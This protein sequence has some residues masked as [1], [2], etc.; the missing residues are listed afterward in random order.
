VKSVLWQKL[1]KTMAS[2]MAALLLTTS[3][4]PSAADATSSGGNVAEPSVSGSVYG[5]QSVSS[6]A[7]ATYRLAAPLSWNLLSK[8]N[9][10]FLSMVYA[11]S[12]SP[13][14]KLSSDERYFAFM[15][16]AMDDEQ[17]TG[18]KVIEVED[19][20]T[21]QYRR[22]KTPDL[23]G[24]VLHFDMSPNG[25]YFA[26]TY[27]EDF[28]SGKVKVYKYD[29]EMDTLELVNGTTSSTEFRMNDRD[30][31]SINADGRYIA[32]DT[33]ADGLVAG[34]TD[35][36]ADVYLYDALAAGSKLTRVSVPKEQTWNSASWAPSIS[37]DG[38][39]LAFVSNTKLTEDTD[40]IGTESL[41][42][43]DRNASA[44][45]ELKRITQG[46]SPS[47]SGD[48]RYIAFATSKTN[49]VPGDTNNRDDI[50]VYDHTNNSFNRV[51]QN[52]D[53][54][55]LSGD[56]Q[57]P[58][59]SRN[60]AYVAYE[61]KSEGGAW[62]DTEIYVADAQGLSSRRISVPGAPI[63]L[64][65]PGKRPI[66]GDTGQTV[67]FFSKYMENI[68]G[69][70]FEFFDYF[71][72]GNG[73]EP[74]WPAGSN[75]TATNLGEDHITLT[76]TPATD[77]DG[78]TGYAIYK[79]GTPIAY[80]SAN[81][82]RTVTLTH[83]VREED[84]DYLFRVEAIDSKY[85]RSMSGPSY[86]WESQGGGNP[87]P[88]EEETSITWLG[89]KTDH[90]PLKK[91]SKIR[92]IAQGATKREAIVEWAYKEWSGSGQ[93]TKTA[94]APLKE[95]A[96][97][98]GLYMGELQL[99]PETTELTSMKL[100]LSGGGQ[101]EV[102]EAE[103]LPA[104]V[105]GGLQVALSGATP[106]ELRG[107]L[108]SLYSPTAGD[109][110]MMTVRENG[111]E[112]IDGLWPG[113][114][115]EVTLY[116]S[117][118]RYEI[119]RLNNVR[120]EPGRT[121]AV[122]VPVSVPARFQVK[123]LDATG[124]PVSNVP[125]TLW[126][127]QQQS[128]AFMHTQ[129]DGT[130]YWRDGLLRDQN[131]TAELDLRD[132]YYEVAPGTPL[133][134]KLNGGDNVLTVNL[135]APGKGVLEVT[136]K[137]PENKPVFNAYVTATQKVKSSMPPVVIQ[138]HTSLDGK[139][140]FE[141]FQG[142]V[143][144]EAAEYSYDYSSGKVKA[145]V[146]DQTTTYLDVPVKQPDQGVVN[147]KVYKKALD[148]EWQGPLDMQN[149][150]FLSHVSTPFGWVRTYYSNA[151]RLGGS[152]GT[153]VQVCVSGSIHAY[154][155]SCQTVTMDENSNATAEVRLQETGARVQGSVGLGRN[156]YYYATIYEIKPSGSKERVA[157]VWDESF[158]TTPFN[159]NVPRGGTFRMEIGR[160]IRDTGSKT[161]YEYAQVDFTIDEG[162]IKS[163]GTIS[164]SPT[165]YFT[166]QSGN[167]FSA[168]PA[169]AM[170][171]ST[172]TLRAAYRNNQD[173]TLTNAAL[174]LEIPQG[175]SLVSDANG[176]K[177]VSGGKEPIT[178]EGRLLTVPLG[179]LAKNDNGIVT[180]KLQV[181][182][183]YNEDTAAVGA[184]IK[185]LLGTDAV[186]ETLGTVHLDT[187][188][189]T[190]DAPT[191]ISDEG[192]RTVVSGYA[193]A[194]SEISIYDTNVKIGGAMA[195]AAGM[196]KTAVTLVDLGNPSLHALWASTTK[197]SIT[198]QSDKVY[199]QYDKDGPQLLRMAFAQ[200]PDKRWMTIEPGKDAPNFVYTVYPGNPFQ[201]D[202]E[203]TR[204]DRVENV[205]VYMDG[206]EGEPIP[207]VR[208]GDLFRAIVPTTNGSLGGIYIDY[209][210]IKTPQAYDGRLPSMEEVRAAFPPKMR[211]FT[212][213]ST[214]PY[215]LKDGKYSGSAT[216][217][218]PQL[219]NKRM[220]ITMTVDPESAY[221][222]SQEEI[223]L[224]ERSG[225]PAVQ[226]S[227]EVVETDV[228]LAIAIKGYMPREMVAQQ[229]A[230][231]FAG[232][233]AK[234]S[235]S[236]DWGHTAEYFMEIKADVDEVNDQISEIKDQFDGYKEYAEKINKIMYNV[237]TSGMDCLDEMP[238]TAK[239]AG[240]ALAAVVLGEVAKTALGAWT[241]AMALTG[242]AGV[243]AGVVTGVVE[244]K[245]DNYVDAQIDSVGTGF[246]QWNDP[247]KKKKKGRKIADPR[248]IY[249]P[250]GYVY[251]AVKS[252]RLEGVEAK[253]MYL[254]NGVWRPWLEAGEYGQVNPQQTDKEGKYGWDVPPGKWKVEW[255]KNGYLPKS[256]AE[257]DVPPPHTE[258]NAGLV[259]RE[260]PRIATVTGVTYDGGS[261]VDVTFSKY[262]KVTRLPEGAIV[263]AGAG[264]GS[265]EL[266][267]AAFIQEETG[268]N[269]EKLSRTIRLVPKTRLVTGGEYNVTLDA[270]YFLSYAGVSM[271]TSNSGPHGLIVKELDTAGPIAVKAMA[272]SG[273]RVIRLTF[274]EPIQYSADTAKLQLNGVA[275]TISSAVAATKKGIAETQELVLTLNGQQ[276]TGA[277]QL[278]L[279][280]GAV[281]DLGGN[282]SAAG[283]LSL[284]PDMNPGL[285][286]L[287][288]STGLLSP[289]FEPGTLAYT[290]VLPAGTK[291]LAL[292]AT[293]ADAGAK[294]TI[295][296][297][298]AVSGA[299]K[300]I[301]VPADGNI[302]VVVELG[303]GAAVREY[304]LKVRYNDEGNSSGDGPGGLGGPSAGGG[305]PQDKDPLNLGETATKER[306]PA[307]SGTGNA[308]IVNVPV[309]AVVNALKD[310]LKGKE[311]YVEVTDT[312]EEV[313]VELPLEAARQLGKAE[314]TL[315]LKSKQMNVRFKADELKYDGV[316]VGA[317]VRLV[318]NQAETKL[319]EWAV[320]SARKQS[321]GLQLVSGLQF[322]RVE[323]VDGNK[324]VGLSGN[325]KKGITAQFNAAKGKASDVYRY[326]EVA[327]LWKHV[328]SKD[329]LW[330][331][332]DA[333]GPY[334]AMSFKNSFADTVGHWAY[335][336][337]DW[338]ARRLLV[339][340]VSSGEFKP[341]GSVTRAEFAAILVRALGLTSS[342]S[343]AGGQQT[344]TDVSAD[345]WYHD[346]VTA[347]AAS[348]L[349]NGMNGGMFQP[350]ETITREQM[351]VMMSR[352][353]ELLR[354]GGTSSAGASLG[355]FSDS[356]KVQ[357]WAKEGVEKVLK[358]GLM[359]G[360]TDTTFGPEG[361][362]TRAQAAIVVGRMLKKQE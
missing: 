3:V 358:E 227:F 321:E 347:A 261:Y 55:Q 324:V 268:D 262:L 74:A 283:V 17:A 63:P 89:E 145:R 165:S 24:T 180:Y 7:A 259:S 354:I 339:N 335:Q 82:A 121:N 329:G 50:Y 360:M 310:G 109:Q 166:N 130:T 148:T 343:V 155:N 31:V 362:T 253:V 210:V 250:S 219:K 230:A 340:G 28:I 57:Y 107:T 211:D 294:L 273:G 172:V 112:A 274:N 71:I 59:I 157:N 359:Q 49:L 222:P 337:I 116:T 220:T 22:V 263:L 21:G 181:A 224:A 105:G 187:P 186:E 54:T 269:N 313:V 179:T 357:D 85:H 43:F 351:A 45:N 62:N 212:I 276:I 292:T 258:V 167:H 184:R 163:L 44:G 35:G 174:L 77:P 328:R 192:M 11:A 66:L 40:F 164:F 156:I 223:T 188:R 301:T 134:Y 178:V 147:L 41:Y 209:D 200:L 197:D 341:E 154:V 265:L 168:L 79:N 361:I 158:Q 193:P 106:A 286:G 299:A 318:V 290:L 114:D 171:G 308:V 142:E 256:S 108:L 332:A 36:K 315:L 225:V 10:G 236:G 249:D 19:R 245:I 67:S 232:A 325:G 243:V 202:F 282:G 120:I 191:R 334:A 78:I 270:R 302:R 284:T 151:V 206:Q 177:A 195:N 152:P 238:T 205:R 100:M 264:G 246:N 138:G 346:V 25:R 47:I 58:S 150:N 13:Y 87:P 1:R 316:P 344:F 102:K 61:V 159:I 129:E 26:Y 119:G 355:A 140:R 331:E 279:L 317:K 216:L 90:G 288:V 27:A 312:I 123:V 353:L 117:D 80:K 69:F 136:V 8:L 226:K 176:N 244:D 83:Q 199:V 285:S 29:R 126:D 304:V 34:D 84:T 144:L 111:I 96:A 296:G 46:E 146:T 93:V 81:E 14:T 118:E 260:E 348:G 272:E 218:F 190:L 125:V 185:G 94:S 122:T 56:S 201:F 39:K 257:L 133:S 295:G 153:P 68:N 30:Y 203:F 139:V 322:V 86:N 9:N 194:G 72:A 51:S 233:R 42:F 235:D 38:S 309:E 5:A 101:V 99:T 277:A 127:D 247:E 20:Q 65:S 228:S 287:S 183:D 23:T 70:E 92:L 64:R 143:E 103:E 242:P 305:S 18:R 330:F 280:D 149:E 162:Q 241:G 352:A 137:S 217:Q 320:A 52:E 298:L 169:R 76:W 327:G 12:D 255:S 213:V 88:G 124:K 266:N 323:A 271:L 37:A 161:R 60:G 336:D 110:R 115:Y 254:D 350:N 297:E 135:I 215:E 98:T 311:L 91:G 240:K 32:F 251:E 160:T 75:L 16:Y 229:G 275:G 196:W 204:P 189:V 173:R 356:G 267:Q 33:E 15:T 95:N 221:K 214:T 342:G 248:W 141:L 303:G 326:D 113:D 349:V 73:T 131:V 4:L 198:L 278:T 300:T 338:M 104:P 182:H 314:G 306:K 293:A 319:V 97:A 307:S 48:G 345:A 175:M 333:S 6:V 231:S 281:K 239:Q 207:A 289:A 252:N 291:Q 2:T 53:G 170:A 208:E 128:I 132:F 237:E 234:L